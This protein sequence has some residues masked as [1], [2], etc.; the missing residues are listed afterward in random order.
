MSYYHLPRLNQSVSWPNKNPSTVVRFGP[1]GG[2]VLLHV[3]DDTSLTAKV[4]QTMP[5]QLGL[6]GISIHAEASELP[7]VLCAQLGDRPVLAAPACILELGTDDAI[8]EWL[9]NRPALPDLRLVL[10][11]RSS[12]RSGEALIEASRR[13]WAGEWGVG[14]VHLR[15]HLRNQFLTTPPMDS[16]EVQQLGRQ[17]VADTPAKLLLKRAAYKLTVDARSSQ[18]SFL[19][20]AEALIPRSIN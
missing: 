16:G 10:L 3:T 20:G 12:E 4:W 19:S 7:L 5:L 2:L 18:D 9:D 17:L 6:F 8:S 14:E 1:G 11:R 13:I 15:V